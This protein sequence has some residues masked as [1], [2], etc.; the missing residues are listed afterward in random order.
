MWLIPI[1]QQGKVVAMILGMGVPELAVILVVILVIFGPKNLPKLGSS[2]GKTVKNFREGMN[3][4]ADDAAAEV[5][6]VVADV[7]DAED[8]DA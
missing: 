2:L 7:A 4:A 8:A 3:G 5:S 6:E 1:K